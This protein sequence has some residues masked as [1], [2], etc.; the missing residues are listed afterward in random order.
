MS[1][2]AIELTNSSLRDSP[3]V[4]PEPQSGRIVFDQRAHAVSIDGRAIALTPREY[5]LLVFFSQHAGRLLTR[6]HLVHEVWGEH[7]GGGPRTVD[8]HVSRLR[9]K[10]GA[11]LPLDTLRRV[12]YRFGSR[13]EQEPGSPLESVK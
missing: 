4:E 2:P 8:I 12:G 6:G 3:G 5:Q 11:S 13:S 1:E 10:L 7:Y 9:R